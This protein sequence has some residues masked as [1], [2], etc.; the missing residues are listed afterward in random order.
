MA[1]GKKSSGT[2][3][4]SLSLTTLR[5]RPVRVYADLSQVPTFATDAYEPV[6]PARL[7]S[8]VTATVGVADTPKKKRGARSRVPYQIAFNA[9][10]ETLVCVR[11]QRRK[12]VLFAKKK[13]GKGGQRK[14]RWSSYSGVKC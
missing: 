5:S 4:S 2:R 7:F 3:D 13:T 12:E 11:R 14:A 6:R 9:P 1:K 8:G 10:K